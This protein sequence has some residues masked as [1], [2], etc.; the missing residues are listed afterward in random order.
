LSHPPLKSLHPD[1]S[2]IQS[3]LEKFGKLTTEELII[4]LRPGKPGGLKVRLDGTILD[5]H[6]RIMILRDRGIDVN[7][8]P[9]EIVPKSPSG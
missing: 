2:L 8:L 9:R 4:S 7:E 3:K 6:H 1:G 5:G